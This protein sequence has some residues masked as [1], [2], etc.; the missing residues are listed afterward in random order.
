ML[1]PTEPDDLRTEYPH[2]AVLV[3]FQ[4]L[5][6]RGLCSVRDSLLD[7]AH[8]LGIGLNSICH[9]RGTCGS[10][11][12]RVTSGQVS[13][14]TDIEIN[15]FTS[16]QLEKGWRLACQ[17]RPQSDCTITIPVESMNTLQRLQIEGLDVITEPCPVIGSYTIKLDPPSLSDPT[18]DADRLLTELEKRHGIHCD[19]VDITV[20]Q[21]LSIKLRLLD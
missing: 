18:A 2:E 15:L 5:G 13:S 3:E 17:A 10:C 4:P 12:V 6:R 14:L 8:Q 21:G 7:C 11:R 20:L 9:G 19:T 16:V 1:R